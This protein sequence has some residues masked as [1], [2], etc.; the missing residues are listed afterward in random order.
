MIYRARN[1]YG[2]DKP[3]GPNR[4]NGIDKIYRPIKFQWA[5]K[6][7][8]P[9][10]FVGPDSLH[11]PMSGPLLHQVLFMVPMVFL[12][13]I[14]SLMCRLHYT[15]IVKIEKDPLKNNIFCGKHAPEDHRYNVEFYIT[16][17][18]V[19]CSLPM[20]GWLVSPATGSK[21]KMEPRIFWAQNVHLTAFRAT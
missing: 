11:G 1:C 20:W 16:K 5:R 8:G 7:N 9:V 14:N 19:Q 10:D 15:T 6:I 21:K 13:I 12:V 17:A 4:F 18:S 2:P 3:N